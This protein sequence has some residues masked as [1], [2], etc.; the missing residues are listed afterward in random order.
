MFKE[1]YSH[2]IPRI[3]KCLGLWRVCKNSLEFNWGYISFGQGP[4]LRIDHA[5]E[6]GIPRICF[7]LIWMAIHIELPF[8]KQR[9][10]DVN[11]SPIYGF[12]YHSKALWWQWRLK[13]WCFHMPWS[14]D[15]VRHEVMTADGW[16]K[17]S[18]EYEPPYEDQRLVEVHPYTYV[19]RSGEV[20]VRMATI[21]QEQREWRW[22]WFKWLPFPRI[23]RT[24]IH[25]NFDGE[26]GERSGSW[27]GGTI[28][29]GYDIRNG[30][31][32]LECL[33]RMEKER[34]FK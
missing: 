5:Y 30:E 3:F 16:V 4:E 17:P 20:Q 10:D 19:L 1:I 23:I 32:M 13:S 9:Y 2:E 26:V 27:K 21:Y 15:H 6:T 31:S 8:I 28:G 12:N 34:K 29:C 18:G 33:M 11:N 7:C 24:S 14:W 25:I 22:R